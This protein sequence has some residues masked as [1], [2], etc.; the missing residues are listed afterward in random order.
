[1]DDIGMG[2]N[3]FGGLGEDADL[4]NAAIGPMLAMMQRGRTGGGTQFAHTVGAPALINNVERKNV[5]L[6]TPS[7]NWESPPIPGTNNGTFPVA[8]TNYDTINGYVDPAPF[9]FG[10]VNQA[11]LSQANVAVPWLRIANRPLISQ[12][13]LASVPVQSNALL[14]E[15]AIWTN[16]QAHNHYTDDALLNSAANAG[17]RNNGLFPDLLDRVSPYLLNF[18]G[19]TVAMRAPARMFEFTSVPSP[20]VGTETLLNPVARA[21]G[22][23]GLD[24]VGVGGTTPLLSADGPRYSAP[25]NWLSNRRVP[26]KLN[27]NTVHYPATWTSLMPG[28]YGNPTNFANFVLATHGQFNP[29]RHMSF[30]Q[31]DP[32]DPDSDFFRRLRMPRSTG[33]PPAPF[34]NLNANLWMPV[35]GGQLPFFDHNNNS[36]DYD[37]QR[38]EYFRL[39]KRQ[40]MANLTTQRSSV[41]AVWITVG[42]FELEEV[43]IPIPDNPNAP[44]NSLSFGA[45][46][47]EIR[48]AVGREYGLDRGRVRRDRAFY[49]VDRSIPVGFFPGENLNV[50]QAVLTRRYLP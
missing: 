45:G 20:F 33:S 22:G 40:R 11:Y 21:N 43:A 49:V 7:G 8:V 42:Y 9:S 1:M 13:E 47:V 26:G 23:F 4:T 34:Y 16:P 14:L 6:R 12:F 41:F 27:L 46:N 50:D 36:S 48:T 29:L 28:A 5:W 38:N 30:S 31:F 19:Q 2:L 15:H 39:Q 35:P 18:Y 3:G 24:L 32:A 44:L 37:T 25:Y 17:L 10:Q